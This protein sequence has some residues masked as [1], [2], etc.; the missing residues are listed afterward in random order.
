MLECFS[1]SVLSID[2]DDSDV[3]TNRFIILPGYAHPIVLHL[4][5]LQAIVFKTNLYIREKAI[6]FNFFLVI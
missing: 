4:D 3:G 1:D 2:C 5:C 6:R